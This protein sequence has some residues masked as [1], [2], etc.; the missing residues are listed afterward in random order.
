MHENMQQAPNVLF[1]KE[2]QKKIQRL[3]LH[4]K[5]ILQSF[6]H[7]DNRTRLKG[8]G[9]DFDQIRDYQLGDDIRFIDWKSS[10][11]TNKLLVKQYIHEHT[12][13]VML[14]VDVSGSAQYGSGELLKHEQT[15]QVATILAFAAHHEKAH[16]GL[17]LFSDDIE[18]YVKPQG[19][20]EHIQNIVNIVWNHK[21]KSKK[22][23]IAKA[24]SF[25]ANV[26]RKD[27]LLCVIS[28]FI[29]DGYQKTLSYVGKRYDTIV[30]RCLDDYEKQLPS[31]GFL[32]VE[33]IE[34]GKHLLLDTRV[35]N[36]AG[37]NIFSERI[38]NQN[39]DFKRYGIDYFDLSMR[40]SS[41]NSLILFFARRIMC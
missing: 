31:V 15:M 9:I 22:T 41:I 26:V 38:E 7:G 5:R 35:R 19:G 1:Q 29:D 14:L 39:M 4:T 10:A 23:D 20:K 30:F 3:Q 37:K 24:C 11:R 32:H 6:L 13:T 17:I 36:K 12:K 16:L 25:L 2:V 8:Y 28:D 40:E 18:C 33:D 34:T 27:M 21:P